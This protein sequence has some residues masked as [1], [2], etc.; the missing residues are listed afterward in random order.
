MNSNKSAAST[1]QNNNNAY[2]VKFKTKT[3]LIK[4]N[5]RFTTTKLIN[6]MGFVFVL[7]STLWALFLFWIWL[8]RHCYCFEI[9]MLMICCCELYRDSCCLKKD[10]FGSGKFKLCDF[11][12]LLAHF[13][14]HK[15]N[16]IFHFT[17]MKQLKPVRDDNTRRVG[18]SERTK[19]LK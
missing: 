16:C 3:M 10:L 11:K 6:F 12:L 1:I 5:C 17:F 7:N 4:L 15:I 9:Q 18:K 8:Y 13:K 14:K 2:K 19:K